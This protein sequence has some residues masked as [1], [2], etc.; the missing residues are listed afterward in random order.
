M[1]GF[2]LIELLVVIAIIGILAAIGVLGYQAYIEDTKEQVAL[3]NAARIDRAFGHDVMVIDNAITDGRTALATDVDNVISRE[4]DCIQYVGA[5]VASLNTNHDN[6]FDTSL[7]YAVSL[8]MEAHWANNNDAIG[9]RGEL[10]SAPLNVAKLKRGQLGLQCANA[11]EPLSKQSLFY[12]H[13]CSCMGLGGCEAHT[14][15]QGDGSDET[16]RY[17]NEVPADQ[18]WDENGN[19]LIGSHLPTWVCPKPQDAG[20]SCP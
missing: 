11:C 16:T 19:I 1:R 20:N 12:I 13:R 18:R 17:E 5:A 4:D 10:R 14:F 15:T 6:A 9:T 3:G 7:P 8:H 2:S